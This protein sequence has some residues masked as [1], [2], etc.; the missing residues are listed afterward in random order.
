MDL[1]LSALDLTHAAAWEKLDLPLQS[2]GGNQVSW[3]QIE[4]IWLQLFG[5]L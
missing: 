3:A 4:S 2:C 1:C 5:L